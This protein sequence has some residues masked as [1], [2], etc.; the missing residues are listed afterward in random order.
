[1]VNDVTS[2]Q[3]QTFLLTLL[4]SIRLKNVAHCASLILSYEQYI[5][6]SNP[7]SLTKIDY[8]INVQQQ[9]LA[10][11]EK[12][13]KFIEQHHTTL[14]SDNVVD[15][16]VYYYDSE[17]TYPNLQ[18]ITP[19]KS[20]MIRFK[21][22]LVE[23]NYYLNL[24]IQIEHAT[25]FNNTL[26]LNNMYKIRFFESYQWDYA[27]INQSIQSAYF[28]I[29]TYRELVEYYPQLPLLNHLNKNSYIKLFYNNTYIEGALNLE[30]FELDT[31]NKQNGYYEAI[32]V[33]GDLTVSHEIVNPYPEAGLGL[34]VQ[35]NLQTPSLLLGDNTIIVEGLMQVDE[36]INLLE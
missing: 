7:T 34:Y 24:N 5:A 36:I 33:L 26:L 18:K 19:I 32:Y 3:T 21:N 30:Y 8:E 9:C 35:G 12:N 6:L 17:T 28:T 10:F 15:F 27:A 29:K 13:K 31:F 1:M 23:Q 20:I 22:H 14:N 2:A 4:D 25:L 11:F 16:N